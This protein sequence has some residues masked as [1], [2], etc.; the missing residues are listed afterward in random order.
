[1]SVTTYDPRGLQP[2]AQHSIAPRLTTLNGKRVGLLHNIKPNAK[3]LL[4]AMSE[5]LR[6][7]Y[8]SVE[9]GHPVLTDGSMR[10]LATGEQLESIA[11]A[12]DLVLTG[13][14]D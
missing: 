11:K 3:E 12:N 6:E 8:P 4:I 9:I 13:L 7:R 14:G 5:V 10:M 1:M 2:V